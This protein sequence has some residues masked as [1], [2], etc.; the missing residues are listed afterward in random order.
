[1]E[2][3][4]TSPFSQ[5]TIRF[6]RYAVFDMEGQKGERNKSN[7]LI[8]LLQYRNQVRLGAGGRLY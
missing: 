1:M 3:A 8:S 5:W 7:V 6:L 4:S 2:S